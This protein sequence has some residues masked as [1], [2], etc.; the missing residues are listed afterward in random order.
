MQRQARKTALAFH[1]KDDIPEVRREVFAIL[2]RHDMRFFAAVRNKYKVADYVR[3]RNERDPEYRYHPNELYDSL[4]RRLFKNVL[5]K[6]DHYNVYFAKR[7]KSDRTAA[8]RT[9]IEQARMRFACEWKIE[10]TPSV[11]ITATTPQEC[12]G[13]QVV[14]YFLW[15]LQRLYER[16]EDRYVEFL[17]SSFRVVHDVDDTRETMYGVYYTKKRPLAAAALEPLSGI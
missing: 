2:G 5:H 1:A 10:R 12:A 6:D 9:A 15:A 11:T 14:D 3:Q 7:G 17:W 13:V 4:V 16:R 8:L